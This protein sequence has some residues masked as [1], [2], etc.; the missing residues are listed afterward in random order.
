MRA[1]W[2]VSA[3][4]GEIYDVIEGA[5]RERQVPGREC[6]GEFW[7]EGGAVSPKREYLKLGARTPEL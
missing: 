4:P 3:T 1:L 5:V 7:H 6:A 2:D